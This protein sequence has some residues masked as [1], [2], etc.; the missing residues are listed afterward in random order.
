MKRKPVE[1]GERYGRLTVVEKLT[2]PEHVTGEAAKKCWLCHCDCGKT[3]VVTSG[4]LK[5]LN[6]TSCGCKGAGS[7]RKWTH[8][9]A[10][11]K[12]FLSRLKLSAKDRGYIV[13]ETDDV[14]IALAE[15]PCI[16]CGEPPVKF[17]RLY[18]DA[19]RN[20]KDNPD[21]ID[22]IHFSVFWYA[23]GIDRKD[24]SIGYEPGNCVPCCKRCNT[25]K[26]DIEYEEWL[27]HLAKIL[28]CQGF[29]VIPRCA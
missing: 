6:V 9:G 23:S 5:G 8:V 10:S 2:L 16:Y 12:E 21:K 17:T 28:K 14:L 4:N 27:A 22:S 19:L 1:I 7:H 29:E 26:M 25:I 3:K 20:A 24:N 15:Q 13:T 18:K 11:K